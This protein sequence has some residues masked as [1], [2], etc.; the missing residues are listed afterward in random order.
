MIFDEKYL[1]QNLENMIAEL[2]NKEALIQ[3]NHQD[4]E[5]L[6][7]ESYYAKGKIDLLQGLLTKG[8]PGEPIQKLRKEP[9]GKK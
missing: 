8:I 1:Q 5:R 6:K 4:S 2:K 9:E 7:A 3:Q